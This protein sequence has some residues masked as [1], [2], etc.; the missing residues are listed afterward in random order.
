M[1]I[2]EKLISALDKIQEAT[3]ID[4]IAEIIEMIKSDNFHRE[5]VDVIFEK[6]N[7]TSYEDAK[8]EF[9]DLIIHYINFVLH[10]DIIDEVEYYNV[11]QLKRLFKIENGDFYNLRFSKIEEIIMKQILRIYQDNQIG[12][13]EAIHKS[14]LQG[15]FDLSYDEI[16]EF[17]TNEVERA[18]KQGGDI[19]KLDAYYK[20]SKDANL[21]DD[22]PKASST[23]D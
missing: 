12:K 22:S 17:V 11:T 9:L 15:M 14:K 23:E 4:Y 8:E 18:L 5:K 20:I 1:K 6:H 2:D 13:F 16:N 3:P 7:I 10:D 21:S 19:T